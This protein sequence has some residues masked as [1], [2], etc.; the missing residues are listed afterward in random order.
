MYKKR[1]LVTGG[2]GYIGSHT[3]VELIKAGYEV[4]IIDN[5]SNSR[6]FIL[7]NIEHITGIKP[8]LYK[9]DLADSKVLEN[10][11]ENEKSIDAVIHFAAFKS[12]GES[13]REP[14][15]YFRNNLFSLVNLLD[16]MRLYAVPNLV[17][18]SSATVYGDPDSL[19]VNEEV[20]F[21]APLSA[22]GSTKQMGEEILRK[23]AESGWLKC[24]ALRYFNP[25][26]A[27]PAGLLGE[28]PIGTPNN[29]MP[30]VTQAASG[31]RKQITV[32]G[33]DYATPDGTCVRDYIHVTDLAKAHVKS[34]ERLLQTP[35]NKPFEVY[36]I[37]TGN[38]ISVLQ[39]IDAFEKTNQVKVN[40]EMGD[41]REG[42]APSVY[43]DVT[44]ANDVLNWK[45]EKGLKEMV[46]DVWQWQK[47]SFNRT[48][49]E[50]V[51]AM[52]VQPVTIS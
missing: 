16:Y 30:L 8:K 15:K 49:S 46:S 18:S 32:Y 1:I 20:H 44:L 36:N 11:F 6:L 28:L 33:N 43:A 27:Y 51:K 4:V 5:L 37:G 21:K 12:V 13:V 41:R 19:P 22:Y 14:L 35:D 42:D 40:Y 39:I 26:G 34:C 9:A 25:V 29:L 3:V 17:F 2:L 10:I 24:I 23:T 31:L 47:S 48:M 38:G 52:A 45:A 7:D 50:K